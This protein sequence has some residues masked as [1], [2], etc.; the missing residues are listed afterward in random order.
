MRPV[1]MKNI[2]ITGASGLLGSELIKTLYST[3]NIL[4]TSRTNFSE[5]S[6]ILDITQKDDVDRLIDNFKPSIIINC[7]AYTSVDKAEI[8]KKNARDVNVEGL[9]NLIKASNKRIKIIHISSDY[10]FDG[11]KGDYSEDD[12]TFPV[13][14]YGKTKLESENLLIGSNLE[15][16]II[17]PN[18]LYSN[19]LSKTHF[20]SWVVNSLAKR[21]KIEVV[22]DQIN[23]PTYIP[24]LLKLISDSI[25]LDFSGI[26]HI[27]SEDC[28][29]R[30]DFANQISRTFGFESN[31]IIPIK[32]SVLNQEAKRPLNSSLN[33]NKV[34]SELNMELYPVEYGIRRVSL[35]V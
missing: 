33:C 2:L 25:L 35:S 8:E 31:L 28:M 22:T 13:N 6:N 9:S 29:S 18:V 32:S 19:D 1:A 20:L 26:V 17:R 7:A 30:Y 5:N 12:P 21:K 23:N 15:F 16:L 3:Y 10:V 4:S 11:I 34:R 27:G 14:Y 24:D